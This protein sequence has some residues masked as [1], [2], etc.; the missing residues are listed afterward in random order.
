MTQPN[1]S[2]SSR[3]LLF[4]FDDVEEFLDM[5]SLSSTSTGQDIREHVMTVVEKFELNPSILCGLTT[6][7][8][9][10]MIGRTNGFSRKFLDAVGAQ[11][12]VVSHRII[13]QEK[14]CTYVLA[15]AEFIKNVVHYV[16]YIKARGLNHR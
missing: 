16:N 8:V 2:Y 13:L 7:G 3:Q 15:L 10:S 5:A 12:I 11:D 9:P 1:L 14:L 4:G 6:N